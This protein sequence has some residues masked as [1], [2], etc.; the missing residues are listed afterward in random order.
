MGKLDELF[1]ELEKEYKKKK[2]EE[3]KAEQPPSSSLESEASKPAEAKEVTQ[4]ALPQPQVEEQ[5]VETSQEVTKEPSLVESVP[6]ELPQEIKEEPKE[7]N[8]VATVTNVS[9]KTT[10][11]V[12]ASDIIQPQPQSQTQPLV[13]TEEKRP[14][15]S[16]SSILGDISTEGEPKTIEQLDIIVEPPDP[17]EVWLISGDKDDGKTHAALSFIKRRGTSLMVVIAFDTKTARVWWNV[18]NGDPRIVVIPAYRW[19]TYRNRDEIT[20]AAAE[21][22]KKLIIFLEALRDGVPVKIPVKKS[23]GSYEVAEKLIKD[24]DWIVIDNTEIF[25][26]ICEFTARFHWKLP[27][28]AGAE[29]KLWDER[30]HYVRELFFKAFDATRKGVIYTTYIKTDDVLIEDGRVVRRKE[31]PKWVDAIKY[32]TDYVIRVRKDTTGRKYYAEIIGSKD[33]ELPVGMEYDITDI[34]LWSAIEQKKV[35]TT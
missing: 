18:Y 26:R 32:E 1:S 8:S 2:E 31:S 20:K 7:T 33:N 12:N 3:I 22:Y 4:A 15:D 17:K 16:L 25:M 6:Q 24:P 35:K 19:F 14:G 13:Q 11:E 29:W 21:T 27:P 34:G 28:F 9:T 30:N 5:K 23:D 10:I